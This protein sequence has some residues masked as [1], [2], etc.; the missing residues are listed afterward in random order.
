MKFFVISGAPSTGKTTAI[1]NIALWLTSGIITADLYGNTLPSFL[2]NSSGVYSDLSIVIDLKGKKI[3]IHSATDDKYNMDLLI[4]KLKQNPDTDIVI[5]SCR[6]IYWE[7]DYF[8]AHIRPF[9]TFYL[10]S[11]KGKITR[12][13]DYTLAETCYNTNML[14]M[15]QHI[16]SNNP[17]N[18]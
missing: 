4:E 6:D 10:E 5:T 7:R 1:N 3:I 11:P 13:N 16:L 2:P 8:T 9:A 17:Y 12:R 14:V 18:L 15:N